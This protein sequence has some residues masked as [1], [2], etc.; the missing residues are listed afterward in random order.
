MRKIYIF[1][2]I[3]ILA[4]ILLI[5]FSQKLFYKSYQKV[6][7]RP[8][9]KL[10]YASGYVKPL[11]YVLIKAEVS[12]YVKRLYVKE[13]DYVRK[14]EI[15]AELEVKGLPSRIAEIEAKLALIEE[16]LRSDSD[17]QRGLK[18]EIEIAKTNLINEEKKLLRRRELFKEGLLPKESLDEA[19]RSFYNAKDYFERLKNSFEDTLKGL[20]A[21]K[22]ALLQQKRALQ[23][24]VSKYYVQAPV[25]GFILKKYVELGD[26]VNALSGENRLFSL[27]SSDFEVVL[28][29]D[30]EY[31]GLVKEGQKV[32][33]AF[34]AYPNELF[35][36][37]IILVIREVERN[38]RSFFAKAKLLRPLELPAQATAEANIVLEEREALVIPLKAL[39]KDNTVE[40]K[41]RGKVRIQV[42]E[43]FGDYVEVI[44]GLKAGE[45]VRIFE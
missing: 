11:N 42:G 16:R 2:G 12:G 7:I 28:E 36:G 45:E 8:V 17:F 33:L 40:V 25:A 43:K 34:D 31:A 14:G 23:E 41:G 21:E 1:F 10:I 6:E 4:L 24:E 18:R 9:K 26:Y 27:G 3:T 44:S 13:G 32:F 38:K 39:Q 30:E 35:E 22:H 20:K 5:I 37:E 29:V 15:L 19:E